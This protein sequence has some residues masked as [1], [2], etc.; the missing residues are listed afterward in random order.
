[1]RN[2]D[3]EDMLRCVMEPYIGERITNTMVVKMLRDL[4]NKMEIKNAK[5]KNLLLKDILRRMGE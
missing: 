5:E 3:R 2:T 1:M 4:Y